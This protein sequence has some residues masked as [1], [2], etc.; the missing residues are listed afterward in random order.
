[1]GIGLACSPHPLEIFGSGQSKSSLHPRLNRDIRSLIILPTSL[2]NVFVGLDC[3]FVTAL[4]AAAFEDCAAVSRGHAFAESMHA[5]AAA[6]LGL[7]CS[8]GHSTIF[9]LF[10]QKI[11]TRSQWDRYSWVRQAHYFTLRDEIR[12]I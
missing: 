12:S 1:M 8:L 6:D 10:L 7:V 11:I 3:E 4:K 9:L 2:L 5:H